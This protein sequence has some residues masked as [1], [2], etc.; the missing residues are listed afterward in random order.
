MILSHWDGGNFD[1][2]LLTLFFL[3]PIGSLQ[4]KWWRARTTRCA[5]EWPR[6]RRRSS[7]RTTR[8]SAS[9]RR[10][11]TSCGASI[12]WRPTEV[13]RYGITPR[14]TPRITQ[15]G[16]PFRNDSFTTVAMFIREKKKERLGQTTP[17]WGHDPNMG[18]PR[19]DFVCLSIPATPPFYRCGITPRITPST[20]DQCG[21]P[22][23]TDSFTTVAMII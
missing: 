22:F 23:R 20:G 21:V 14:I 13:F 17:F 7:T 5:S 4:T 11:P 8:S 18:N 16:V 2:L 9:G 15:C 1:S 10:W 6:W 19:F 12:R 3:V